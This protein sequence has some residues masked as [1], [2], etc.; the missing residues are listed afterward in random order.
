MAAPRWKILLGQVTSRTLP[1]LTFDN[2]V[3]PAAI[4]R[5]P[6]VVDAYRSDLQVH[7][8]ISSRTYTEWRRAAEEGLSRAEEI[9]VPFFASHGSADPLIDPVGT[10]ELVRRARV[11]GREL[12]LYPG[13]LHEPFNDSGNEEV[14]A[15]L[16]CWLG[17]PA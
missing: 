6:E 3:D 2:E 1:R 4:S 12:R 13:R 15:D 7:R 10:E 11:P 9:D 8:S 5:L 17:L 16:A 14:F